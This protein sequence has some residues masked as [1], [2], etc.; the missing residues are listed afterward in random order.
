MQDFRVGS[1]NGKRK[2]RQLFVCKTGFGSFVDIGNVIREEDFDENPKEATGTKALDKQDVIQKQIRRDKSL[3][4]SVSG[5]Y[6]PS[7]KSGHLLMFFIT[8]LRQDVKELLI[9]V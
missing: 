1:G 8:N 4:K 9:L 5:Y 6:R 7:G 3:T 2:G